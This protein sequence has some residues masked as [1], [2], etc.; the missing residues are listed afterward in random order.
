[1]QRLH[2]WAAFRVEAPKGGEGAG[3]PLD[4]AQIR[5]A[6]ATHAQGNLEP[7]V[8]VEIAKVAKIVT[9]LEANGDSS[10]NSDLVLIIRALDADEPNLLLA[11][12]LRRAIK[13]RT[14]TF[15]TGFTTW[16]MRR[17][18]GSPTSILVLGLAAAIVSWSLLGFA[19]IHVFDTP[20]LKDLT[21]FPLDE[22]TTIIFAA[23]LGAVV[24]IMIRLR[25]I[26]EPDEFG[27]GL[28]FLSAFFKP[29]IGVFI[30]MF[31]YGAV[32]SGLI[33]SSLIP[34]SD[35]PVALNGFH[36]VLGFICGFSERFALGLVDRVENKLGG[37][38]SDEPT[39]RGR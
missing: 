29:F 11:R 24:S 20:G 36:W 4:L 21:F 37:Q 3:A 33:S 34:S 14:G 26:P 15:S 39:R 6:L 16:F 13:M 18:G 28:I 31:A 9:R 7:D 1:M 32:K 2:G 17:T 8:Q 30:A 25:N 5:D 10:A 19:L 27:P 35:D 38:D 12:E 22:L 23:V